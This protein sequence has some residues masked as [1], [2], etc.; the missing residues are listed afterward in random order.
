MSDYAIVSGLLQIVASLHD[1]S[2]TQL[3]VAEESKPFNL[4]CTD[5]STKVSC[6]FVVYISEGKGFDSSPVV[7]RKCLQ[8]TTKM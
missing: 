1:S 5:N 6:N 3:V 4:T 8:N 7:L 2:Q